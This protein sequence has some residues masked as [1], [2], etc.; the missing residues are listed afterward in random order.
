MGAARESA[1]YGAQV[2]RGRQRAEAGQ[3]VP[4]AALALLAASHPL[5]AAAVTALAGALAAASGRGV[6]GTAQV[7][8]AFAAGQLSVGWCN[9]WLDAGRDAAVGR[10]DK[11]VAAGV[12]PV[13]TVRAAALTA[14]VASVPL[15]L[16]LGPQAGGLHL[17]AVASAWAYDLGLKSTAASFLP[18]AVSFGLLPSIVTLPRTGAPWWASAAAVLLGVGAHLANALPDLEDDRRTGI[19]NLPLRLGSRVTAGLAATLLLTG[20]LVLAAGPPGRPGLLGIVTLAAAALLTAGGL[21]VGRRRGSRAP[22][23]AALA[24]AA[25]DVA[26]L[27]ARG[28]QLA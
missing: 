20:T 8:A 24:V 10:R 9:D 7:V 1:G 22:F 17:L 3:P 12:V 5:P 15:S 18:Y 2:R 11:P 14:L 13:A 16:L 28:H 21:V 19:Q 27:V 25:L 6:V 4:A 26:L 23:G